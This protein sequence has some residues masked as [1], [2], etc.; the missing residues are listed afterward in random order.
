MK[1]I[2]VNVP[3]KIADEVAVLFKKFHLRSRVLSDDEMEDLAIAKSIEEGMKT[4]DIPEEEI[5]E[6]FRKNGIKV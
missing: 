3:E 6:L 2:I 5:L 4:E 1:T